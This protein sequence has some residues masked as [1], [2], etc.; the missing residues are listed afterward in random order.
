MRLLCAFL[1]LLF[2]FHSGQLHG[3]KYQFSLQSIAVYDQAHLTWHK[4][5]DHLPGWIECKADTFPLIFSLPGV[6]DGYAWNKAKYLVMEVEHDNPN[7][8]ILGL[9]FYTEIYKG[10]NP[11]V[12]F[13]TGIL[14]GLRTQ[15]IFPLG[16][17]AGHSRHTPHHSRQLKGELEGEIPDPSNLKKVMLRLGP[18]E[19]PDNLARMNVHNIYLTNHVPDRLKPPVQAYVD[20]LWQ[21]AEKQWPEKTK[22]RK[23]L[24]RTLAR[25]EEKKD[26][27]PFQPTLFQGF[28]KLKWT[29]NGFFQTHFDGKRWWFMDPEG[30]AFLSTGINNVRPSV[31][32][33][34]E[35]NEDLFSWLP[36]PA[37]DGQGLYFQSRGLL[38]LNF[39]GQNLRS[40][41]GAQWQRKWNQWAVNVLKKNGFNTL[42]TFSDPGLQQISAFPYV[43]S[44]RN[45]PTTTTRVFRDFPDVFDLAFRDSVRRFATQ[46]EPLKSDRFLIGYFL[47]NE[48]EWASDNTN[49]A[50]E[51]LKSP[52][53]SSTRTRLRKWIS[54]KYQG[55]V[56][57]LNARWQEHYVF[58]AELD[59]GRIDNLG[60]NAQTDL[61]QFTSMM[62]DSLIAIVCQELKRADPHHL[63]LGF[64][65]SF[66]RPDLCHRAEH[67]FDVFSLNGN[68]LFPTGITEDIRIRTGKP[69]LISEF[70]VGA[71]DRGLPSSGVVAA[72]NQLERG[73][74]IQ[75]Y[76]EEGFSRPEI[77]GIHYLQM[78]DQPILGRFDGENYGL[79]LFDVCNRVY[80]DPMAFYRKANM[81]IYQIARGKRSP[82]NHPITKIKPTWF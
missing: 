71:T 69:V 37:S 73:Y 39:L 60:S 77:I 21:Q 65:F 26:M 35:G 19:W 18:V 5:K 80:E 52:Q 36:D 44:L 9:D 16:H 14:P 27:A 28:G 56:A 57:R 47:G 41:W 3:Q 25:L 22:N 78:Y 12:R 11:E 10:A 67:Q 55:D 20:S 70:H 17:L 62:V 45:F 15:V 82:F 79:G 53:K 68:G 81:H 34:V 74:A 48:P 6:D 50:L 23:E 61:A 30:Y 63:N 51:I 38:H 32:G 46:L 40:V 8:A 42:G 43:L 2:C 76:V 31:S 66:I 72:K 49:I 1:L 58:F 59:S 7:T 75:N 13:R 29:G 4:E 54:A 33:P 64:R 24:R